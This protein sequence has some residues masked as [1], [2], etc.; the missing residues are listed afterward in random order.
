MYK[1]I[2]KIIQNEIIIKNSKFITV[3]YPVTTKKE[4][5]SILN[6]VNAEHISANHNCY[7]YIL[8]E[9]MVQKY[10]D[11]GEPHK[12]AGYPILNSLLQNG[13]DDVLC[14][15]TRY[16]GGIKLGSGGLI[17]AYG[18]SATEAIQKADLKNK[19][20]LEHYELTFTYEYIKNIDHLLQKMEVKVKNKHFYDFVVYEIELQK[21]RQDALSQLQILTKKSI[22]IE[23]KNK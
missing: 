17:R 11:D 21:S 4:V 18:K 23:K 13:L 14:V 20:Y 10:S 2:T 1:T 22:I 8:N 9:Q 19:V 5:Q 12:T 16:F 3:L 6:E 7:A 15:V